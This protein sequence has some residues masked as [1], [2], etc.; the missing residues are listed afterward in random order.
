MPESSPRISGIL[1]SFDCAEF[2][3]EALQSALAQDCEPMELIV[4]DDASGDETFAILQREIGAYRGPHRVELCRR[5]TNAGSKSAHLNDAIGRT[6]GDV[7]VSFDG[8]DVSEPS[9]VRKIVDVFRQDPAVQAV[10]SGYSLIDETGRSLGSG[11]VPHPPVGA[12]TPAWFAKVDAY[13]AGTTLAVRRTV[14]ESFDPL[15]PAIHED[16]VLPFRA[17]LL[18]EVRYLDE[19]LVKARRRAGSLTESFDRY[20]SIE[21]YRSRMRRGIEQARVHLDSR[22]ADLRSAAALMPHRARE[23]E[24]LRQVVWSS[25]ADAESTANLVDPS[26]WFR[27][28]ALLRLVRTGAYRDDLARNVCLALTPSWYLWYKRRSLGTRRSH[29]VSERST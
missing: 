4:S 26:W 1:L 2:V 5:T 9:R 24:D 12:D 16:I 23:L 10:Y 14:V 28:R 19:E 18:G 20:D 22:L 13:A 27:M 21:D 29:V 3:A 25:M 8:D 11:R 15:D 6:T 17:S 7:L